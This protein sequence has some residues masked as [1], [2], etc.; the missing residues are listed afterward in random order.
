MKKLSDLLK[1]H[2]V[3]SLRKFDASSKKSVDQFSKYLIFDNIYL[4]KHKLTRD[5]PKMFG[6]DNMNKHIC[7]NM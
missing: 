4:G 3:C 5:W 7:K 6:H 2:F 1:P